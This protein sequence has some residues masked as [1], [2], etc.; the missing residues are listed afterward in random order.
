MEDTFGNSDHAHSLPISPVSFPG[1]PEETNKTEANRS[2]RVMAG[3]PKQTQNTMEQGGR[4]ASLHVHHSKRTTAHLCL[5]G[6]LST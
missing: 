5:I 1:S 2:K 3:F 4:V 6:L